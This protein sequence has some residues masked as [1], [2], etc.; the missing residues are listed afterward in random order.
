[1]EQIRKYLE[2]ILEID[3]K[4]W[5]IFSS[6]LKKRNFKKKSNLLIEGQV[7][8]YLS[9]IEKG[10]V[11][12]LI[13]KENIEKEITFGF[14][15]KDEFI[16]AYDSFLTQTPSSYRL[17]ALSGVTV[18]SITYND[19]QEVYKQTQ[20]GNMIGRFSS[21]RLFL[22]KSKREQSLLNESAEQRYLDL[23]TERP[24]LI[25][26]IP[27]KYIASYIGVTPQALSRIRRRIS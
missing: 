19:L 12:F 10:V 5:D 3:E 23:F 22:I 24:N 7:E 13:P 17:E 4:D 6:K 1:M 27:L 21:E 9:F 8:N 20:I 11:R 25:K 26:E 14:C 2:K 15:F 16:S 18:W